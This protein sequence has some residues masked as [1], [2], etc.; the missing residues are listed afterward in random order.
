MLY[1]S[2]IIAILLVFPANLSSAL[3][4][5]NHVK[6]DLISEVM[7]VQ[8]G[9]PF[10]VDV[11]LTMDKDWHTYWRNPGDSGLP[12]KIK[13]TLPEG[14]EAGETQWP[15]PHKFKSDS[16][17]SF[18]YKDEACLLTEI[19]PSQSIE[20]G[21]SVSISVKVEWIECKNVCLT[22]LAELTLELPVKDAEPEIDSQ[23][24]KQFEAARRNLPLFSSDWRFK[25]M[26]SKSGFILLLIPPPGLVSKPTEIFFFPE[27]SGIIDHAKVQETSQ[28]E[29]GHVLRLKKSAYALD[30]TERLTGVLVSST[31][32]RGPDSEKAL[33]I[34]VPVQY[35]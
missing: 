13:W 34:D 29:I 9:K 16:I 8:P 3:P 27:K 19:R 14:F 33:K 18:G 28:T 1:L 22:G 21:G 24:D 17:V 12:T 15:Y 23:W 25:A 20:Q 35:D 30:L 10:W 26:N 2:L 31:G 32:W 7:S 4:S 11:R 5:G 6:A